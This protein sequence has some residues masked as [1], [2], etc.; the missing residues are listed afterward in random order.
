H[1]HGLIHRDLK[2]S[3]IFVMED[4]TAKIIDFGLV[5]SPDAHSITG[6]KGTWQY[7]APEQTEGKEPT[8]ESDIYA[9]GVVTYEGL[10]GRKPFARKTV[11]A[12]IEAIRNYIPP[13]ISEIN[14]KVSQLL[15]KVIHKAMAKQ[16]AHR[17]GSAK[18][19][20]ETL[21]KACRNEPIERFEAAKILPRIERA[22]KAFTRDDCA[23]ASEI[24]TEIEAEGNVDPEITL[25]RAQIEEAVKQK[26]IR[27]L[28]EAAQTRLEQDEIPLALDKLREILTLDP[29]NAEALAMRKRFEEQRNKE[30]ISQ[31]MKLARQHVELHDF[32]EARQALKEV[33]NIRYD[34]SAAMQLLSEIDVQEKEAAKARADKE[35]LYGSALKAYQGG[36][37]STALSK[38]EKILEVAR[39]TPGAT[40]PERDAVYQSFYNRV[41]SE[42]DS[43]DNTYEDGRRF[44]NDKDFRKALEICNEMLARYPNIAQFQALK[45]KVEQAER[46]ELS[47]Y[48]AEVA[49]SV[50]AEPDLDRRVNILEEACKRYPNEGQFQ[51]SQRLAREQ[52]DLVHSILAKARQYEEQTQ[53]ADAIGQWKIL[54]NIH[55]QYLGIDYEIGQLEKRREQQSAE[56]KKARVVEQVDRSI[57]NGAFAKAV[58]LVQDALAEFPQDP[59]L[60]VLERIARQG[61]ERAREGDRLF[62]DAR[63]ARS[64]GRFDAATELLRDALKL[65]E[66]NSGIRNALISLLVERAHSLLDAEDWRGSEP[67][68]ESAAQLDEHHPAVKRLRILIA[69][70]KRR[71]GITQCVA[72]AR[73]LQLSGNVRAALDRLGDGLSHYPGDTRLLQFQA[74]LHNSLD[75]SKQQKQEA[76]VEPL[77]VRSQP[78]KGLRV[79]DAP[80]IDAA[81]SEGLTALFNRSACGGDSLVESR[82]AQSLVSAKPSE[83]NSEPPSIRDAKSSKSSDSP[84]FAVQIAGSAKTVKTAVR[85]PLR[86][87]LKKLRAEVL[88]QPR[89]TGVLLS[90]IA[91][92][93]LLLAIG[94]SVT[95]RAPGN[96]QVETSSPAAFEANIPITVSPADATL[97]V[98]GIVRSERSLSLDLKKTY[99]VSV[100]RVGYE[101]L[102]RDGLAPDRNG[103]QFILNPEPLHLQVLTGER[104][105]KILLDGQE[106]WNLQQGDLTAYALPADGNHHTLTA[107][108]QTGDLFRLDFQA[109]PG[110]SPQVAPLAT[111]NLIVTTTLGDQASILSGSSPSYFNLPGQKAIEIARTGTALNLTGADPEQTM[112][113]VS[114]G[115]HHHSIAVL[116]GNAPTLFVSLNANPN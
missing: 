19:F 36:E 32:Q 40:V 18:E 79:E 56:E 4:D 3:N 42:R 115:K 94:M 72:D 25:L 70:A 75:P 101:G 91:L 88:L 28:F 55:P 103:W 106:I 96:R 63:K 99:D 22:R 60:V 109:L 86:K 23:F 41:R 105:G 84:G 2:P 44:L 64:E 93:V 111:E 21:Q 59:E 54:R 80:H 12:T 15:S 53:F 38:L 39:R 47:A 11:E 61:Q 102:K 30:Q 20:A 17:Y 68:A 43:I 90:G 73:Q 13:S 16:S 81:P 7:M 87:A 83:D 100:S 108:N 85:D 51:Q 57:E 71:D 67:L 69:D 6:Y 112:L 37:I 50:D 52:R 113:V 49:R 107:R 27:Q 82:I 1:R 9:V 45:L 48:I 33:L 66:R 116:H 58:E 26:R 92:V 74:S 34:D 78:N 62:E 14:P 5:H 46:Q 104:S 97:T 77:V 65:D 29:E 8:P 110:M 10:T 95:H 89:R 76:A 24:L 114:N 35:Q 98:N 31:W